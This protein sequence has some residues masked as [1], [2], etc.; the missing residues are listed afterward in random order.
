MLNKILNF[1]RPKRLEAEIQ[2]ELEFHRSRTGGSFGN[3]M[4]IQDQVRDA[5]TILWLETLVQDVRYGLRQLRKA[6]VLVAVAVLSLALG[7]GA[8]T[9]IFTLINAVML[10]SLPVRDPGRLVLFYDG[11]DAGV[12]SGDDFPS[13]IFSYPSWQYL[14]THNNSFEDLCAFR[15]GTDRVVMHIAGSAESGPPEEAEAH[16]VSGN[17]FQVLGVNAAAG[18]IL[19]PEDDANNAPPAAVISYQFWKDHFHL[20]NAVL[21][22]TVF[23]NGTAFVIVGVAAREFFG[24]RIQAPPDFWLP[25]SFE[26]QVL[27]RES[28][29]AARDVYWLNL[30]GRLKS[31]VTIQSADAAVSTQLQQFY[32]EQTGSHLSVSTKRKIH[33]VHLDLKPGGTGIS[34]LR[35]FYSEPLH[36]LMAVVGIVLLIA[37]A[38]IATLLLA[39]ASARHQE[40]LTRLALGASRQRLVRQVLTES[41]LL[42]LIGGLAGTGFAWW[43]VKGLILLLHVTPVVKVRPD[44]A[45]LA[46]TLAISLATGVLFGILPALR[47]SRMEPR[48]GMAV[49][50]AE[51]GTSRI[52]SAQSLIVLQVALSF[53]LLLG[54]GLLA[55]SLVALNFKDLGFKREN[56][57]VVNTDPRLAGYQKN[58]LL[59]FYRELDE[60]LNQIP[61]V[62]SA[63]IARYTPESGS[64]SSGSFSI[65]GYT[66]SAG[67]EMNLY[68]VEVSPRFFETLGIPVLLGRTIGPRDTPASPAVAV[69]NESFVKEYLPSQNPIG[70]RIALGSPFRPPGIEIVGVVGDSKYYDLR[71]KAEPMAFLAAWQLGGDDPYAGS[72]LLRTSGETFGI[73]REVRRILSGISSKLP[74]LNVTTLDHQVD[75]SLYQQKMMT[76]LCSIFGVAALLL[77]AI[78]IYGTVAYAV[79][80]RTT[81]IGIRIAIGAQRANVLW[82]VL[83]ESV[84]LIAAGLVF[85]LPL[86]W[87]A[88]RWIRTFLFGVPVADPL[89]IAGAVFLIAI[90]SLVAAYLPA[91]RATKIDPMRALRYE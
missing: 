70:R 1:F 60:R 27:Q 15:Q 82:M 13:N 51:F 6:P 79:A 87:V 73:K 57:L 89:A 32:A 50:P 68:R 72:L 69:V 83:R 71:E 11:I 78:G 37:C 41:V 19:R 53:V 76:S 61:G 4:L 74:V 43:S 88:A 85:G 3:M 24:V 44:P 23:L 86:A 46:F 64:S 75:E 47:F 7:I 14:K 49:R 65:Q 30:L 25:L 54:A 90:A 31:G 91:S 40:F 34:G 5:S 36:V 22:K 12:Y 35:Y 67:K 20:D 8:N 58:E 62:I 77:A 33:D 81:E 16:L 56:V 66:T 29:L 80:R 28:W 21:G 59:P 18:R 55:R 10:Q 42:S 38:N 26:A 84:V 2:E 45:V 39:R 63:S 48:L 52:V 17:Y 9:A